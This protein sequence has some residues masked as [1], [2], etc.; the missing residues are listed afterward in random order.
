MHGLSKML[1]LSDVDDVLQLF[2]KLNNTV[3]SGEMVKFVMALKQLFSADGHD[4][5]VELRVMP[6][7]PFV[8]H[9]SHQH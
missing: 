1:L 4:K 2:F 7:P 9:V 6:P 3:L 8:S 5:L